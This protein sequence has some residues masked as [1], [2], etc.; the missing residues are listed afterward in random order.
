MDKSR[1]LLVGTGRCGNH[2]VNDMLELDGRY[3]GL[4]VNTTEVD[5]SDL[6]HAKQR[7]TF[8]IPN[9]SGTGKNRS[10]AKQYVQEEQE[11]IADR[12]LRY[13]QQDVVICIASAD[14]G[15]GSG[16][17]PLLMK[18]TK[19]M[20]EDK[21]INLV[22]VLP[23]YNEGKRA[24]ENTIDFWNEA[25][26]LYKQGI[27]N[28]IMLVDNNKRET[29]LEVNEKLIE[30]LD[31]CLGAEGLTDETDS[32][33]VNNDRG[34][35]IVLNLEEGYDDIDEA[36]N[37][38]IHESVFVY[39]D[40]GF[41]KCNSIL[42]VLNPDAYDIEKAKEQYS[43]KEF[44]KFGESEEYNT[45]ILGGCKI[46][47]EAINVYSGLLEDIKKEEESEIEDTEDL[48]VNT[49]VMKKEKSNDVKDTSVKRKPS[50]RGKKLKDKLKDKSIWE[51]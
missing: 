48:L 25:I 4:F 6:P 8:I 30:E 5:L 32:W 31:A 22:A 24:L 9:A 38:C 3:T 45:L 36:I 23:R 37:A 47:K 44:K 15:S 13:M 34:Y 1:I 21:T 19:A 18:V 51:I 14:G 49:T 28:S 7:N 50:I 20:T 12:V 35:K 27:I 41:K 29:D 39:P 33:V 17:T 26:K 16:I 46:P 11:K 43:S 2:I 42:G 10:L 40:E